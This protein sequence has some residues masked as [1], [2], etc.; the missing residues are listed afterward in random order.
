[1]PHRCPVSLKI[2]DIYGTYTGHLRDILL[3]AIAFLYSSASC[4]IEIS[5][6][7]YLPLFSQNVRSTVKDLVVPKLIDLQQK[8]SL[9]TDNLVEHLVRAT[10]KLVVLNI[11]PLLKE[12]PDEQ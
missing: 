3:F 12:N 6:P 5:A 8:H 1:M 9:S 4:P 10:H 2:R 11:H 7:G